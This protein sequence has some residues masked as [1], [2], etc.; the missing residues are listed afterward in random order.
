[1]IAWL[2]ALTT[3]TAEVD[4]GG[5]SGL[6]IDLLN[7]QWWQAFVGLVILLGLSPA[8]WLTG[9]AIGRIQFAGPAAAEKERALAEQ[10]RHYEALMDVQQERYSELQEANKKNVEA[11]ERERNR[12]DSA[13]D[14]AL[15]VAQVI[16][17][18]NH[19]LES[20]NQVAR[21]AQA[22]EH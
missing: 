8:P 10:K 3:Y 21:E 15:Q 14:A 6:V 11:A 20:M 12:A 19:V 1:V 18:N 9:L 16:E 5:G 7:L 22:H 13:T 2:I 4:Q 17:A